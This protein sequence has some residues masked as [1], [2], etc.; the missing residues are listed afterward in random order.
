MRS[1]LLKTWQGFVGVNTAIIVPLVLGFG[2][3]VHWLLALGSAPVSGWSVVQLMKLQHQRKVANRNQLQ[4]NE[5][6]EI[7]KALK[8][9]KQKLVI[10]QRNRFKAKS[11][12]LFKSVNQIYRYSK[13]IY[14]VVEKEPKRF[15][16]ANEFF[17]SYLDSA[18]EIVERYM[19]LSSQT[20]RDAGY[21]EALNRTEK[22]LHEMEEC[23]QKELKHVVSED[24][25]NLDLELDV[26]KQS[27]ER[28]SSR[29]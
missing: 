1:V 4:R 24:M 13:N 15:Y 29:K 3:D 17:Y 12:K 21:L 25:E 23:L 16:F 7:Q 22:M 8:Q 18:A 2:F 14:E 5:Y 19:F 11:V 6:R 26:F 28:T 20:V 9:A 10:L 27:L